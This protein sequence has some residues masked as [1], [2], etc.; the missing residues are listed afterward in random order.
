MTYD[1]PEHAAVEK[2]VTVETVMKHTGQQ[3]AKHFHKFEIKITSSL[4]R[5]EAW[6]QTN[7][8]YEILSLYSQME[9][10]CISCIWIYLKYITM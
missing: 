6:F 4:G 3:Y 10:Y 5:N 7:I 2:Y 8:S 1:T 9:S